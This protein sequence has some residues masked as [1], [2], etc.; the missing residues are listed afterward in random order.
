MKVC[1]A[2]VNVPERAGPVDSAAVNSTRPSPTP[3]VPELTVSHDAVLP[4]LHWQPAAEC[5]VTAP[6]VLAAG[7]D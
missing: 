4:A 3:V 6:E 5:T 7:I 1:P 2:T